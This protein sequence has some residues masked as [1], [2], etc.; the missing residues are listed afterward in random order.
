M[1]NKIENEHIEIMLVNET[2]CLGFPNGDFGICL[3][4]HR[5]NEILKENYE[6]CEV[7]A[8]VTSDWMKAGK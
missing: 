4:I 5:L 8:V 3:S 1:A 6:K 2:I 7:K